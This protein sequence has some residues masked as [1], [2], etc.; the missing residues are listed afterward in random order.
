MMN[1]SSDIDG[2]ATAAT[3]GTI[4]LSALASFVGLCCIGPWSV[5]LFGVTG[6]VALARWQPYRLYILA[7]AAVLL[8]W[9]FWRVYRK[10][11][12]GAGANIVSRRAPWLKGALWV[13][14][15]LLALAW[16]AEDLQWLVVDPTPEG[17]R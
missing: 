17:L 7:V 15:L 11:G 1:A 9:G 5:A 6:A 3:G 10:P 13:S 2:S 8:L 16:F 4:G 14:A 12:D